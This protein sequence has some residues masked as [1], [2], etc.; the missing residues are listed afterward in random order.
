[1]K[2]DVITFGSATV[3]IFIEP[4][5]ERIVELETEDGI[6]NLVAY[7]SGGKILI[8][9][10]HIEIGGGGTNA[11]A[12]FARLGMRVAFG[13][14]VG[15]D[16]HGR[17][18]LAA[19]AKDNIA[20][21]GHR[22]STPTNMSVIL[23]IHKLHDRT[24]M[25]YKGSS[26]ELCA[27]RLDLESFTPTWMYFSSLVGKS[28]RAMIDLMRRARSK[29]IALAFN[30]SSYQTQHGF[31]GIREPLLSSQLIVMNREE[32]AMLVGEEGSCADLCRRLREKGAEIVVIT[33]GPRGATMLY[34]ETI[35]SAEGAHIENIRDTTGAGDC[36]AST[37][38]AGLIMGLSP[39]QS[40]LLG[41]VNAEHL[42]TVIGAK[43][44]LL[45]R[46]EALR[47]LEMDNRPVS[48]VTLDR[49]A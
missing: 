21:V 22:C 25:V 17:D 14:A 33:D 41:L 1:M 13:G 11:A 4:R 28:Y 35:Y 9:R 10:P 24:I 49:P 7:P 26:N 20:F 45:S 36:F 47:R 40:L 8:E 43:N 34:A 27:E 18:V 48:E 37:L 16:D 29:G 19:L 38:V 44:G 3:D 15:D 23:D 46:E 31:E 39:R 5:Q 30:P 32:A 12:T 2:Y 42:V 6:E